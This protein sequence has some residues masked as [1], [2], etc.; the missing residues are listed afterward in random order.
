[1]NQKAN[2]I[3]DMAAVLLLQS[4]PLTKE[5]VERKR[6]MMRMDGRPLAKRGRGSKPRVADEASIEVDG[7]TGS[8]QGVRIK[9]ADILDAEFAE[10]WPEEVLHEGLERHRYTAAW[11]Q[12]EPLESRE[13]WVEEEDVEVEGEKMPEDVPLGALPEASRPTVS[14]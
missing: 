9:W 1:M 5:E 14:A 10:T 7:R 8:V 2:S 11:P 6:R 12:G 4:K 13:G 3:A